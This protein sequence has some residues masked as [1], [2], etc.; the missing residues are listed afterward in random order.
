MAALAV[1]LVRSRLAAQLSS[2]PP[3]LAGLSEAD[4]LRVPTTGKWSIHQQV[5][6]LAR[7]H[8]VMLERIARIRA[9]DSP[10]LDR[11]NAELDPEWPSMAA[12]STEAVVDLLRA[13]RDDLV[14]ITDSLSATEWARVGVHPVLG[15]L[16]LLE[17]VDFF[18]LHE[19]HHLYVV[20]LLVG[21]RPG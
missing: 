12:R 16:N 14:G 20:R 1:A 17:W 2:L 19:A 7:H 13:L 15:R 21:P 5:A 4:L 8:Q 6:H 9:E 11:Y 10:A 18:L 3:M